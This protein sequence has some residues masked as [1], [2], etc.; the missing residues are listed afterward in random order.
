MSF[1]CREW[2]VNT[3]RMDLFHKPN[4]IQHYQVC[5]NHFD[6]RMHYN[7]AGVYKLYK[8]ATPI[9]VDEIPNQQF[10][11]KHVESISEDI[12]TIA[13]TPFLRRIIPIETQTSSSCKKSD[14]TC[15]CTCHTKEDEED[16]TSTLGKMRTTIKRLRYKEK[17]LKNKVSSK[18]EPVL[19]SPMNFKTD[20][21]DK[22][23]KLFPKDTGDFI[24]QQIEHIGRGENGAR[25]G[26]DYKDFCIQLSKKSADAYKFLQT[27]FVLPQIKQIQRRKKLKT[28]QKSTAPK[29]NETELIED[30]NE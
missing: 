23:I 17:R 12:Q 21:M 8:W 6:E 4:E 16:I 27:T 26:E 25:Y 20:F 7:E 15:E 14:K 11:I 13:P 18:D 2:C 29:T 1:R 30:E 22:T 28:I 19:L 5:I 3:R 9:L 10:V 24:K